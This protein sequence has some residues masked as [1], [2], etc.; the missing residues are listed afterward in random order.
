[1]DIPLSTVAYPE[2]V[3]TKVTT[4]P[5]ND[6]ANKR[7]HLTENVYKVVLQKTIPAQIRQLVVYL[8]YSKGYVN[9]TV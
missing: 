4:E 9:G 7:T 2:S 6:N 1:M 5:K 3:P 8:G